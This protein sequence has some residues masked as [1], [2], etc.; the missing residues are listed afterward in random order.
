[1]IVPMALLLLSGQ[2]QTTPSELPVGPLPTAFLSFCFSP[3]SRQVLYSK[4]DDAKNFDPQKRNIWIADADG[5]N[6][7][8]VTSGVGL[9]EWGKGRSIIYIK[10]TPTGND[11]CTYDLASKVE[12]SLGLKLAIRGAHYSPSADKLVFMADLGNRSTQ[13]FTCSPEGTDVRQVTFGPGQAYSPLWSPD[14]KK[15]VFFRE[16]GDRKDQV[17]LMGSDG[18]NMVHIS[19]KTEHNF[20]PDFGP[21]GAISYTL[22][23]DD[24]DKTIVLCNSQGKRLSTFPYQTSRLRWSPDGKRA[25]FAVGEFPMMALYVSN[26]DGSKPKRIA[27]NPTSN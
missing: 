3:D 16:L 17:Y 24:K 10:S 19:E 9:A 2:A 23:K 27:D 22:S 15:I 11:L 21:N 6:A 14:G 26:A 7:V 5:S 12:K 8:L 13:V 1:M 4:V 18:T 25:V 20:Y